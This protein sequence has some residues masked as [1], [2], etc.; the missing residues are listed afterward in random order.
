MGERYQS[1]N[2]RS[3]DQKKERTSTRYC[4]G[5]LYTVQ[6]IYKLYQNH[7]IHVLYFSELSQVPETLTNYGTE[8]VEIQ[9][10]VKY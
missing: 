9:I 5:T 6:Y 8:A 7:A 2:K 1:R 3:K 10:T 4:A